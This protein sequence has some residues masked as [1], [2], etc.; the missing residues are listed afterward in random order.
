MI[1]VFWLVCVC[2]V[3]SLMAVPHRSH[4]DLNAKDMFGKDAFAIA[5]EEG[6]VEFIQ[7]L[8]KAKKAGCVLC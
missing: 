7:A 3:A 8:K 1:G 4:R 6:N 5:E 2:D